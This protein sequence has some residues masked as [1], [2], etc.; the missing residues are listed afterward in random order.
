VN[1]YIWPGV[2]TPANIAPHGGGANTQ[3]KEVQHEDCKSLYSAEE[4]IPDA[5]GENY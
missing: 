5:A 4:H 1:T 2:F 3:D